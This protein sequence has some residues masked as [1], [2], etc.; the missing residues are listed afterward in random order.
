MPIPVSPDPIIWVPTQEPMPA[1]VH[2]VALHDNAA[3]MGSPGLQHWGA[4][5]G[6]QLR[7]AAWDV[8]WPSDNAV[9]A[10]ASHE[11][12]AQWKCLQLPA[13]YFGYLIKVAA[14]VVLVAGCNIQYVTHL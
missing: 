4:I 1:D 9:Y 5:T 7:C 13:R 8:V 2:A 3:A 12:E 11:A 14:C 10:Q 6:L